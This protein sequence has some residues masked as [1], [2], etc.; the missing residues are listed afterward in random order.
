YIDRSRQFGASGGQEQ[1]TLL[2]REREGTSQEVQRVKARCMFHAS[3]QVADGPRAQLGKGGQCLL[4]E[5]CFQA[6]ALEQGTKAAR[7]L[8]TYPRM[9]CFFLRKQAFSP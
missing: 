3:L 6:I 7:F 8:H 4:R 9:L 1:G 2:L 5:T